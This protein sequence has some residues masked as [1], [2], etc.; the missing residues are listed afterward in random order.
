V[1]RPRPPRRVSVTAAAAAACL[2]LTAAGPLPADL[3]GSVIPDAVPDR[4]PA[5]SNPIPRGEVVLAEPTTVR[6]TAKTADGDLSDWVGEA[7]HVG[8]ATVWDAGEHIYS[9]FLFDAHGADDGRDRDRLERFA[10]ALYT[11]ERAWR[12]D[13]LLRTSGSQLGVP[14]PIGAPDEYGDVP[15]GLEVADLRE[16]RWA[17]DRPGKRLALLARVTNLTEAS[18]LGVLVLADRGDAGRDPREVGLGTELVTERFDRAVLLTAEGATGRDLVDGTA[19]PLR[20]AK[21]AVT[22]EGW[23]NALEAVLPADALT[24]E[25]EASLDVAV[26]VGRVEDDGSLTPLNVAYRHDEPLEIWNDRLQ[27]LDLL[28]GT[29][30]RFSSGPIAVADLAGGRTQPMSHLGPGYHERQMRSDEAISTESGRNGIWQP[31]G[32]HVPTSYVPGEQLPVTYWLHYRGGKAHSGVVINPRLATQLGEEPGHLVVFPHGRGTS[33]WYV[34]E[35]HQDV[36]EVM[37]DVESL[38]PVDPLRR[39]ISGYSM[40]GY[41]SWLFA[42]LYPDLFA[43]AFVQSGAV[44]Q[45]AWLGGGPDDEPDPFL[46][47]GWVEANG[48]DARAQLTYR[49][50]ENLRHVPFAIDHGTNDELALN[51]QV[52]RMAARL[53]ELGYEHRFTRYLGYEHFTQAA[54][55]EWADGAAWLAEQVLEPDPRQVTY[56]VVPVLTWA[57][58]N[59]DPPAGASFDFSPDRAY[60]LSDVEVRD[61]PL[62]DEVTGRPAEHVKGVVDAVSQAI[63]APAQLPLVETGVASPLGHSTPYVRSGLTLVDTPAGTLDL[64]SANR[65]VLDLTN[66]AA[67]TADVRRADLEL[68]PGVPVEVAIDTDGP[69]TVRLAGAAVTGVWDEAAVTGGD[70]VVRRDGD[71]VIV[72]VTDTGNLTIRAGA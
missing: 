37:A 15:G 26:V 10:G 36:L 60:W 6:P 69:T 40:G 57:V 2:A 55:D 63:P 24:S 29:V 42:T 9:D 5:L 12:L 23:E 25:P 44:T 1:S 21:V 13:Q 22:A 68:A 20:G 33:E 4:L 28:E 71:D 3:G 32:V 14:E 58:N 50:L 70:A 38:I 46:G 64:A 16:V 47:E 51:P 61:V 34:T 45:G 67:V 65:L 56:A 18:R 27:A 54:V 30:D 19:L 41:G 11:E 59:V 62:S 7:S 8:G 72:E 39:T 43:G 66:V 53:T 35:S 17:A 49:A 48:G 31:Y 52:E